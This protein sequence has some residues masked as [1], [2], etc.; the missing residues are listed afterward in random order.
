MPL[1]SPC[2]RFPQVFAVQ[3]EEAFVCGDYMR[4]AAFYARTPS[5]APFEEVALKLIEADDVR[6]LCFNPL[7]RPFTFPTT[8]LA[9]CSHA[10]PRATFGV[11]T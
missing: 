3:A 10:V 9:G 11:S 1:L 8:R 6:A 2:C 4:A 5:A 7:R